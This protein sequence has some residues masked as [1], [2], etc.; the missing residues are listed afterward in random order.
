MNE[1]PT[2]IP[3]EGVAAPGSRR[4][5][6]GSGE[7]EPWGTEMWSFGAPVDQTL[8]TGNIA[9][10][11]IDQPQPN[12]NGPETSGGLQAL[13]RVPRFRTVVPQRRLSF[14][15]KAWASA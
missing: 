3:G 9:P 6:L 1:D 4:G 13:R 10:Q 7:P 11:I 8:V 15:A 5:S 14:G 2:T 12:M